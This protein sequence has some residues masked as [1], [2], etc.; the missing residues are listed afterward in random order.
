MKRM[1]EDMI[2]FALGV[3]LGAVVAG[4][5]FVMSLPPGGC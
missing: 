2:L 1:T 4:L 5:C 3:G